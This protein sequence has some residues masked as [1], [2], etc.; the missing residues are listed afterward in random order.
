[1][2]LSTLHHEQIPALVGRWVSAKVYGHV[3]GF[4]EDV[5][6]NWRWQ[7]RR[8]ERT[9]A[10]PNYPRYKYFGTAI[11]YWLELPAGQ[12]DALEA[13]AK[14][15]AKAESAPEPTVAAG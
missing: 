5:L 10:R 14:A 1:M 15:T 8:A 13:K 6:G 3:C 9:E 11:R 12:W 2:S 7:D 4:S